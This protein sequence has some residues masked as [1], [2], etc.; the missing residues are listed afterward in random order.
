MRRT[1]VTGA[2]VLALFA[3]ASA[4]RATTD[5]STASAKDPSAVGTLVGYD[6]ATKLLTIRVE[7]KPQSFKVPDTASLRYGSQIIKA[8]Q[9]ASHRGDR[10]KVRYTESSSGRIAQSVMLSPVTK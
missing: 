10:V 9:L 7:Q 5:Q 4:I 1:M 6:G 2:T 3:T 8:S